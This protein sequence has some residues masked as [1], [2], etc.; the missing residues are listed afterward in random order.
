MSRSTSRT[1]SA[2]ATGTMGF[3][4]LMLTLPRLLAGDND[5]CR[6]LYGGKSVPPTCSGS[7]G[8][9]DAC[10]AAATGT[11]NNKTVCICHS[12]V[13]GEIVC[14]F[15]AVLKNANNEYEVSSV[16]VCNS[17]NCKPLGTCT[18]GIKPPGRSVD[19]VCVSSTT[20]PD[21]D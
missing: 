1:V 4:L 9:G 12:T 14:C 11:N 6:L 21:L 13:I 7:C 2:F 20:M 3:L 16:G 17:T 5:N 8:E 10:E 15:P 19:A 18:A